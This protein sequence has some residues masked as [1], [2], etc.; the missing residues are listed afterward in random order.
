[1]LAKDFY[2]LRAKINEECVELGF[3]KTIYGKQVI[4]NPTQWYDDFVLDFAVLADAIKNGDKAMLPNILIMRNKLDVL[5]FLLQ[6]ARSDNKTFSDETI[7][8]TRQHSIEPKCKE[9]MLSK[10]EAYSGKEDKL[11]NFKRCGKLA[12]VSTEQTWLVYF[13][14]HFD[15]LTSFIDGYYVDSEPIN[16]RIFDMRNYFDLLYAITW[17]EK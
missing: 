3:T 11:G 4:E 8:I 2:Q 13:V 7:K 17:E 15:A 12:G 5:F 16:G 14:K 1:M 6:N 10:G 9:I